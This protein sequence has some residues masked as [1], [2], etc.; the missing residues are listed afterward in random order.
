VALLSLLTLTLALGPA[1]SAHA[2]SAAQARRAA[3][4]A[5]ADVAALDA[6]VGAALAAYQ[7]SLDDLARGVQTAV[8]GGQQA[9]AAGLAAAQAQRDQGARVRALYMSGG[10]LALVASLLGSDSPT[11]AADRMIAVQRVVDSGSSDAA[12]AARSSGSLRA[13]AQRLQSAVRANVTTVADV[14]AKFEALQAVLSQADGRL[15]R[16]SARARALT[17]AEQAAARLR[18]LAAAAARA[19]AALVDRAHP[20]A[21]P[22]EYRRLYVAAATTCRG[23]AWQVLAAV[24]QVESGHGRNMGPSSA[25]AMGPMQFM[26]A[27]FDH[28]AVDGDHDGVADIMDPADAI[29][30]AAAY[31]CANGGGNGPA[32]LHTALFHYNHAEW[33]VQLVL[34]LS[35][36]IR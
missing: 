23:L 17:A 34:R 25:G 31:L 6:K 8:V 27:T 3:A 15:A 22:P 14:Q 35:T 16:L 28:Y 24:G 20:M 33:Y 4:S 5:A 7:R 12:V 10:S 29:Y 1:T 11:D 13:T 32:G 26:P 18:A 21:I 9:D 19:G 36:L 30:T 2:E